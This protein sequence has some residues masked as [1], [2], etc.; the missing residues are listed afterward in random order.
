MK[1]IRSIFQSNV[2]SPDSGSLIRRDGF[3][4]FAAP[5]TEMPEGFPENIAREKVLKESGSVAAY[6]CGGGK[7]F[8]KIY[9]FRNFLH[10][11]KRTFRTPRAF[12]CFAGA[13]LLAEY[14]FQTPKPI[15][16]AVR[17]RGSVPLY[18]ILLTE[19]LPEN[20]VYP[21]NEF[22]QAGFDEAEN[23]LCALAAFAAKLHQAGFIHGDMSLRNFY[24]IPE[25]NTFGVIDL[26]G[27]SIYPAGVP[28]KAAAREVARLLASAYRSTALKDFSRQKWLELVLQSYRET[29][30]VPLPFKPLCRTIDRLQQHRDHPV[31]KG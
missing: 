8:C 27:I 24:F 31:W 9:K 19:S 25:K 16:A 15:G 29:G 22:K 18:Q 7:Y 20:T 1:S 4:V 17:Y 2:P 3:T 13:Q 21:G 26:D 5:G 14:G 28:A 10:S 11:L 12:R 30:G 23:M 6:L